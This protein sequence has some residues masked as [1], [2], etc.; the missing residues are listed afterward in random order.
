M[1]LCGANEC[2]ACWFDCQRHRGV[3]GLDAL[4]ADPR[5]PRNPLVDLT[6]RTSI[7]R[8]L[9]LEG[10]FRQCVRF[11]NQV[12]LLT[13]TGEHF[14]DGVSIR[15]ARGRTRA[16]QRGIA[17]R[18]R[19]STYCIEFSPSM[20]PSVSMHRLTHPNC[21]MENLGRKTLPPAATTRSCST[22]QSA[23]LK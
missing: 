12:S 4:G 6:L 5:P 7:S 19:R 16:T 22:A 8:F 18:L 14:R 2:L 23:T 9:R 1:R 11:R 17:P 10:R 13:L 3:G 20:L 21:P 15:P